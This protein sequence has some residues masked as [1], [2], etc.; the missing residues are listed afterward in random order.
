MKKLLILACLAYW[1]ALGRAEAPATPSFW[2]VARAQPNVP[3]APRHGDVTV[4]SLRRHPRSE[5]D[6]YDTFQMAQDFH[7]TRLEWFSGADRACVQKARELELVIGGG[8]GDALRDEQGSM[9]LGRV[10]GKDG[11]P[12]AHPWFSPGT[13]VGC[14]NAPEYRQTWLYRAKQYVDAGVDLIQQDDPQMAVRCTSLC[15]C[16]YC[17]AAFKAYQAEHGTKADYEQFQKDSVLAFHREM[18]RQ[19]DAYAGRHVPFSHN[20]LIGFRGEL[21]WTAPAFDFV[22][23][24]IEGKMAQPAK[25]HQMVVNAGAT[26]LVFQYRETSVEKNRRALATF[27]ALGA[28][29]LLPWDVYMPNHAP[30]YFGKPED[31]ADLSGF[32]RA[33]A[34]YLDGYEEAAAAGPGLQETRYGRTRPVALAGGSGETYAFVRA[35]PGEPGSPVVVHLV[36]WG[37]QSKPF[38]LRLAAASFGSAEL[39]AKLLVPAPYNPELH[40][41][42]QQTGNFSTLLVEAPLAMAASDGSLSVPIPG[43]R[44]WAILMVQPRPRNA[45]SKVTAHADLT[46]SGAKSAKPVSSRQNL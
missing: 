46:G 6:P 37:K 19:L 36:E 3:G 10:T 1:P 7:I 44:P 33:A 18:H 21:D 28:W 16:R 8:L 24:E 42:A 15:Y 32:I 39:E 12:K 43:V 13:W 22:N 45:L 4:R 38:T 27:Y 30:R 14:A 25:L 11:R 34:P 9:E 20:N 40:R 41:Q 17:Q 2:Q 35:R 5:Y 29:M 26:P 31:Y 23:A